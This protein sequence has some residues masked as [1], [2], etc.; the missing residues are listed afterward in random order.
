[1]ALAAACACALAAVPPA[2]RA[3]TPAA[4]T[5]A[6]TGAGA[7]GS[8]ATAGVAGS[9][10][11]AGA[12]GTGASTGVAATGPSTDT[13]AAAPR[14]RLD[15]DVAPATRQDLRGAAAAWFEAQRIRSLPSRA[16][17][18]SGLHQRLVADGGVQFRHAG[19]VLRAD[20]VSYD[21]ADERLQATGDVRISRDGAVYS[22]PALDIRLDTFEGWF[23]SP[24]FDLLRFGSGGRATRL[25]FRGSNKARAFDADYTSC[26]RDE[27]EAGSA[28]GSPRAPAWILQTKRLDLDFAANEGLAEGAVL[29]FMGVPLLAAPV[30][31]FP[32]TDARKSG[33]LPPNVN[34]DSRSGFDVSVPYYWNIA[35]NRDATITP[36]V[37]TRRGLGADLE[38]RY[39]ERDHAGQLG[40]DALPHDRTVGDARWAWRAEHRSEWGRDAPAWLAGTQLQWKATRVSDDAWWKDFPRGVSSLTP[41]LLSQNVALERG[42]RVGGAE[43]QAYARVVHWQVLQASD[44]IVSPYQRSPQLGLQLAVRGP[45]GLK[46]RLETELNRFT[47]ARHDTSSAGLPEGWRW[48]GN[49]TLERPWE[50]EGWWVR[51]AVSLHSAAWRTDGRPSARRNLPSLSLDAGAVFERQT[52]FLGRP[53]RQVLEPRVRYV[54]TPFRDQSALPNYDAAGKD[55][56]VTSIYADNAWSGVDR[57]SDSH[58]LTFGAT[59]RLVRESD[60][61]EVLRLGLVQR[62]LLDP[63]RVTPDDSDPRALAAVPL[64]RRLSDV[65]LIGSTRVV[66]RW[67]LEGTVRYN[68]DTQR[69]VRSVV[70]ARYVAD[71]YRTVSA[72][73]RFTRGQTE[74]IDFGWQWP[75][76]GA[77]RRG[78]TGGAAVGPG[79]VASPGS[80]QG[81]L[82]GVGRVNYSL[83]DSRITDSLLGLEY[84]SGCWIGRIVAERVS[85]GR[86]EA[87]TRLMLQLELVGLSRLGSNPLQVL[88]DN[89][90]GY[91]LLRDER[92]EAP[93]TSPFHD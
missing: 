85:T 16:D 61:A 35:P 27:P 34:L 72:A 80:C 74:Q 28:S 24:R 5:P 66:P 55:F 47:L 39:L 2:A 62:M 45:A 71:D 64:S 67:T 13:A 70:S 22:G 4:E 32:I 92:G 44:P 82:F 9:A 68:A 79:R 46:A 56:N 78:A 25:E 58:Q 20:Q 36:R 76:T 54:R 12:A 8:A 10:T 73:Y 31:S 6:T 69:A 89:I 51:P 63:Q 88:K 14:L 29:R 7:S 15:R 30:L 33:W 48:H 11:P 81:R 65:L 1:L 3:Q 19:A 57:I 40:L 77:P 49:A 53:L 43:G 86:S 52:T 90:P 21:T 38:W 23:D 18:S 93:Q 41:R 50:G 37:M 84:D 87:T 42:L 59:T 17:P 60:G 83:R 91:R 26:P 75:I